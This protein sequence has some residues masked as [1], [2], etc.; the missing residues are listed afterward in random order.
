MT[1]LSTVVGRLFNQVYGSVVKATKFVHPQLV[2]RV[3]RRRYAGKLSSKLPFEYVVKVGRPNYKER[4]FIKACVK[5][6]EPFPVRKA[7]LQLSK[8]GV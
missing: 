6:G 2:V 8:Q 1:Q 3:T 7:K 4:Q 5:S